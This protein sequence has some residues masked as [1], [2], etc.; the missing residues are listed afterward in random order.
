MTKEDKIEVLNMLIDVIYNAK[1]SNTS[2]GDYHA[3]NALDA[4]SD[5]LYKYRARLFDD[6]LKGGD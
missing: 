2:T 1:R 5:A 4:F 6:N 3:A